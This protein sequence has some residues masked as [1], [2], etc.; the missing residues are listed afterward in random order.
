MTYYAQVGKLQTNINAL[1]INYLFIITI[2][3][4][5]YI[6]NINCNYHTYGKKTL[7]AHIHLN[8]KI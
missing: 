3:H 5:V 6:K 7:C 1:F 2:L 8:Y 4:S